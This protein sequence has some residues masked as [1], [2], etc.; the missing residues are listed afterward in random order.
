MPLNVKIENV[1]LNFRQNGVEN[2]GLSEIHLSMPS[3][4]S[5]FAA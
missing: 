1:C 5:N 4:D 3:G 2:V